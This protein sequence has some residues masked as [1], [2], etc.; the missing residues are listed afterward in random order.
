MSTLTS[1]LSIPISPNSLWTEP[2]YFSCEASYLKARGFPTGVAQIGMQI[3]P[4]KCWSLQP[5]RPRLHHPRENSGTIS[6]ARA[7]RL[8]FGSNPL[9]G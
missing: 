9:K 7:T 8:K 2:A 3:P 4:T 5:S 1:D 6:P